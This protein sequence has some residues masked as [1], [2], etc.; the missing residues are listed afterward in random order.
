MVRRAESRVRDALGTSPAPLPW[1]VSTL[2]ARLGTAATQGQLAA[3]LARL[4]V[5]TPPVAE[6]LT[7]LAGPYLPV[8]NQPA[9]VA[10]QPKQL[11]ARTVACLAADGGVRR[12]IDVE[13][14]LVDLGVRTEHIGPWLAAS[15]A[16]VVHDVVVSMNGPLVDVV[17]RILDAHGSARTAEQIAADLTGGGRDEEP[18]AL[19]TS[20][21]ARTLLP[22][23]E[24]SRGPGVVGGQR[25]PGRTPGSGPPRS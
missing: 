10:T 7:W 25:A 9:W 4:G 21:R 1:A 23:F 19:A 2:R 17:E 14:E 16:V 15:G 5:G 22:H 3:E 11:Q 6:L 8:P 12:L 18:A 13:T 20:L 24:R